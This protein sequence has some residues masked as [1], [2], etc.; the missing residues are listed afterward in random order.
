MSRTTLRREVDPI[1]HPSVT[2]RNDGRSRHVTPSPPPTAARRGHVLRDLVG[3][4]RST[5]R[6][7]RRPARARR[8]GPG[9]R[10]HVHVDQAG[11]DRRQD[12]AAGDVRAEAAEDTR[13]RL[14]EVGRGALQ[15][16]RD[17][18]LP[19]EIRRQDPGARGVGYHRVVRGAFHRSGRKLRQAGKRHSI[20]EAGIFH[21]LKEVGDHYARLSRGPEQA[22]GERKTTEASVQD[23]PSYCFSFD[24]RDSRTEVCMHRTLALPTRVQ[25]FQGTADLVESYTWADYH[26]NVGLADRDFDVGNPA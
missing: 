20:R 10:L 5:D 13:L 11:E 14:P 1:S 4:Q 25:T 8:G 23:Q 19:G 2:S 17:D 26:L 24:E 12:A 18:L 16:A 22:L 7:R 9:R 15:E 3:G 6:R 21:V